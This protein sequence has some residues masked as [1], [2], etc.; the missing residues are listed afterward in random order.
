MMGRLRSLS[1]VVPAAVP[2]GRQTARARS[3]YTLDRSLL[4]PSERADGAKRGQASKRDERGR[5]PLLV[6]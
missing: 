2:L 6:S 3:F 1:L 4:L 5:F